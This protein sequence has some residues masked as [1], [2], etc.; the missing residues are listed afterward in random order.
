MSISTF[1]FFVA[2]VLSIV[3]VFYKRRGQL[4]IKKAREFI[5]SGAII[6]DVRS[7]AEYDA[8]HLSQA[9]NLPLDTITT[10]IAGTVYDRNRV[11][12][13]HC[14]SGARSRKAASRLTTTGYRSAYDIGSYGRAFY[15][16]T[17]RKL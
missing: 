11:L 13:L 4:S 10:S 2:L 1:G 15:I 14:Q 12:L 8:G 6:I 3:Y 17:G 9:V 5:E 7:K 16:V